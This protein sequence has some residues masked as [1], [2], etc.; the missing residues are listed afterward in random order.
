MKTKIC[1]II[2]AVILFAAAQA[3]AVDV[4]FYTDAIIGD[5]D[6]YDNV[7]VYD[8]PPDQ[9]TVDMWGGTI[10]AALPHDSSTFNMYGGQIHAGMGLSDWS[11]VNIYDGSVLGTFWVMD[12]A[13]LNIYGGDV[14]LGSPSFSESSTVNIFGYDF[15]YDG[16]ELTGFLSDHSAFSI[17]EM[18]GEDYSHMNLVVIPE[19]AT[20][21]LLAVGALLAKR[22]C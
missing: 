22:C 2:S 13:W 18:T 10:G 17:T 14:S 1:G 15:A 20:V 16:W 4:D 12:S 5:G 11:T 21:L 3:G 8:T 19:P 9:T 6:V 7:F